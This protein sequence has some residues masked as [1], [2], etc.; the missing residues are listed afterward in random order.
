M[1]SS[2]GRRQAAGLCVVAAT[3]AL[4]WMTAA[5]MKEVFVVGGPPPALRGHID[6]GTWLEPQPVTPIHSATAAG[7]TAATM[8]ATLAA[9]SAVAV[10]VLAAA[11]RRASRPA[12]RSAVAVHACRSAG[13]PDAGASPKPASMCFSGAAGVDSTG[14]LFGGVSTRTGES[15]I[16]MHLLM[17]KNVKWKKP[18][19]PAVKPFRHRRAARPAQ[20]SAVAVNACRSTAPPDAGASPTPAS[21][22]FSGATGMEGT[23]PLFGGVSTRTGES[24]IS[25]HLLMP[26]NVKWKKPHKP[27]VKPFRHCTK[28]KYR[29]EAPRGYK[30]VFGK[31]ALKATEEAWISNK[32]I[33]VMRRA[34]VRV[35]ERKGK[36]WI[37]VFPNRA[38]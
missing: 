29:G 10:A 16:S 37:R 22:C 36:I 3:L 8:A 26:K 14:P 35:M 30:P 11:G 21:M 31:Y 2:P 15:E 4:S 5:H 20:R 18:H 1:P 13:T 28:W 34:I 24:D 17:P 32:T 23:G 27:A 33:E 12:P 9:S 38:I 19:K 25:M 6:T 7:A